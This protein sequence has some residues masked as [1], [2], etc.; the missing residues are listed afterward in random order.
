MF[1]HSDDNT[2]T[3]SKAAVPTLLFLLALLPSLFA[4]DVCLSAAARFINGATALAVNGGKNTLWLCFKN[5]V[6]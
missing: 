1:F 6:H 3:V 4:L 5:P 2:F